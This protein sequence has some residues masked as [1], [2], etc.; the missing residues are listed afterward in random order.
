MKLFVFSIKQCRR[1]TLLNAPAVLY[2]IKVLVGAGGKLWEDED[3]SA[4]GVT[5]QMVRGDYLDP[6]NIP[7]ADMGK[8]P[9]SSVADFWVHVDTSKLNFGEFYT[10]E[11]AVADNIFAA[12]ANALCWKTYYVFLSSAS[13]SA[14]G[15]SDDIIGNND[16]LGAL[17]EPI[18]YLIDNV[19]GTVTAA[20]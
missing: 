16:Y 3:V 12:D 19:V 1:E 13:A 2:Q 10:Y 15:T 7:V 14:E 20:S 5:E 8:F 6:N 4:V 18:L 17:K 11:E 9:G